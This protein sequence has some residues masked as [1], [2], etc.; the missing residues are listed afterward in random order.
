MVGRAIAAND[1]HYWLHR[2]IV[3]LYGLSEGKDRDVVDN[4][5]IRPLRAKDLRQRTPNMG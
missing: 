4:L 3:F 1:R 2:Q 5:E